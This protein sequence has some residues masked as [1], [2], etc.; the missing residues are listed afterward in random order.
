MTVSPWVLTGT[1]FLNGVRLSP[2]RFA[3]DTHSVDHPQQTLQFC[4]S[5]WQS[6]AFCMPCSAFFLRSAVLQRLVKPSLSRVT[7]NSS[8]Q[9]RV[10]PKDTH[11]D[12]VR[13]I[14]LVKNRVNPSCQ[15]R[16]DR[17][18]RLAMRFRHVARCLC[19][20]VGSGSLRRIWFLRV[21]RNRRTTWEPCVATRGC[22]F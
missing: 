9:V 6:V 13:G 1:L 17:Q 21:F 11:R 19:A 5:D 4:F 8:T 16:T 14:S 12:P 18:L 2:V 15:S 3:P 22:W 10:S 20:L 7:S